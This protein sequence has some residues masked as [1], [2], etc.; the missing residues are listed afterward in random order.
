MVRI[1]DGLKMLFQQY[2]SEF[3]TQVPRSQKLQPRGHIASFSISTKSSLRDESI[4]FDLED[5]DI[6]KRSELDSY[7]EERKMDRRENKDMDVLKY[8]KDNSS[9]SRYQILSRMTR[10]LLSIPITTVASES[11]FSMGG[12]VLNKYRSS[13]LPENAEAL[14]CTRTWM[15]GFDVESKLFIVVIL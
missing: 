11:A 12:K 2:V 4:E 9:S 8:W 13:L 7:L 6:S 3:E 10:D 14:I 15:C 1:L 5:H